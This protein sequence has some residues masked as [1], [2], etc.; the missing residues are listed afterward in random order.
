MGLGTAA[1]VSESVRSRNDDGGGSASALS[2]PCVRS[3]RKTQP[4]TSAT[5]VTKRSGIFTPMG[6]FESPLAES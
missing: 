2:R 4:A 5:Q 3:T 1:S 6:P